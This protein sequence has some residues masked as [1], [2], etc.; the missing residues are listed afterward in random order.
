MGEIMKSLLVI[1]LMFFSI[2]VL[3]NDPGIKVQVDRILSKESKYP[4]AY[5]DRV[6]AW[7]KEYSEANSEVDRLENEIK[8]FAKEE[9]D[10]QKSIKRAEDYVRLMEQ[11]GVSS[12][13]KRAERQMKTIEADRR[14]I[15]E[16]SE[17][18]TEKREQIIST[19]SDLDKAYDRLQAQSNI[20]F[21]SRER[22]STGQQLEALERQVTANTIAAAQD[23]VKT[24]LIEADVELH[25]LITSAEL[26]KLEL[27]QLES[28]IDK[29]PLGTYLA[30]KFARYLNEPKLYCQQYQSCKTKDKIN[31]SDES[32]KKYMFPEV[33]R[34]RDRGRK[35][36]TKF[37]DW[38][39]AQ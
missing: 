27:D 6:R 20:P 38:Q 34:Q 8:S 33:K 29:S 9:E 13:P 19:R 17:K 25:D 31:I 18:L 16:Q 37:E 23:D 28:E 2:N 4:K 30:D 22:I 10:I 32:I 1:V 3:A 12:D 21:P 36:G 39:K 5:K 11:G 7:Y 15:E 24:D 26:A 35:G 14:K